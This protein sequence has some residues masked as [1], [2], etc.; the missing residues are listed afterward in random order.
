MQPFVAV[1][2]NLLL[3]HRI[4][5]SELK[6]KD[7]MKSMMPH[8]VPSNLPKQHLHQSYFISSLS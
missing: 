7:P 5:E 8:N 1:E 6:I 2:T 4:G 3:K